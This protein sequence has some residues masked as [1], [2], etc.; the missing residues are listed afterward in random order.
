VEASEQFVRLKA[1]GVNFAQGYLPGRLVP[2]DEL[3]GQPQS[4]R[5]HRD[6]A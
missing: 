4:H 3:E 1:L 6:A 2:I 5:P